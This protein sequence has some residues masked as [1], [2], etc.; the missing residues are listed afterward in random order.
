MYYIMCLLLKCDR[1][2]GDLTT[3]RKAFRWEPNGFKHEVDLER[4]PR[5]HEFALLLYSITHN[6]DYIQGRSKD[7][8]RNTRA[9][10]F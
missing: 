1:G 8:A 7:K 10:P 6:L 2:T 3:A 5:T 4:I 9:F